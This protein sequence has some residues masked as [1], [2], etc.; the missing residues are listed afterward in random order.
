M[1]TQAWDSIIIDSEHD[2]TGEGVVAELQRRFPGLEVRSLYATHYPG[3]L[4]SKRL[5]QELDALA[6]WAKENAEGV[7]INGAPDGGPDKSDNPSI[8]HVRCGPEVRTGPRPPARP[9][10]AGLLATRRA[11]RTSRWPRSRAT[12]EP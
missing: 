4:P 6:D 11:L 12:F 10:S 5:K 8:L 7:T 3:G 2:I 9:R 1:A